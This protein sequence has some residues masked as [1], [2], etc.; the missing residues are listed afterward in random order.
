MSDERRRAL[1]VEDD[2]NLA[3]A[4]AGI[5]NDEGFDVVERHDGESGYE[6]ALAGAYDV[7]VLDVMLPDATDSTSAWTCAG[8][9]SQ[10]PLLMLTAKDGELDEIEGLEVGADDF[11]R[12]PFERSIFCAR[13]HALVRRHG[14]GRPAALIAGAVGA[15][16]AQPARHQP[17]PAR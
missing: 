14:R 15:R 8:P 10:T 13:V 3:S 11:L 2:V 6:E 17:R 1:V 4:V 5:L 7:I 9:R 16:P 12:K